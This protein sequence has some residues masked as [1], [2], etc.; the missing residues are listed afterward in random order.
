MCDLINFVLE[1]W[2]SNKIFQKFP[3]N[4]VLNILKIQIIPTFKPNKLIWAH[5]KDIAFSVKSAYCQVFNEKLF[6]TGERSC[7]GDQ[8]W[9]WKL[10]MPSKFKLMVWRACRECLLMMKQLIRKNITMTLTCSL[11]N[12]AIKDAT[13]ALIYCRTLCDPWKKVI[14]SINVPAQAS[15]MDATISILKHGQSEALAFFFTTS[16]I[17]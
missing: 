6:S 16:W 14:P 15:F 5:K 7:V 9:F 10:I 4:V 1:D 11:C 3:P 13:Q 8:Q 2:N 12:A 17:L